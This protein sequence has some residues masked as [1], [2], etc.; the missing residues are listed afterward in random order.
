MVLLSLRCREQKQTETVAGVG[1]GRARE[2]A[3]LEAGRWHSLIGGTKTERKARW[4]GGRCILYRRQFRGQS[5]AE[6]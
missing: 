4:E 6:E 5:E 3:G 1:G 2:M